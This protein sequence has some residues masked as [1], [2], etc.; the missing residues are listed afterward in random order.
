MKAN[1]KNT[2][3]EILIVKP[4]DIVFDLYVRIKCRECPNYNKKYCCPPFTPFPLEASHRLSEF[5]YCIIL[6]RGFL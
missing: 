6:S 3:M 4:K 1:L 2:I 5:K